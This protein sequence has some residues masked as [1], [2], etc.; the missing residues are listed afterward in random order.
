LKLRSRGFEF[1]PE[2]TSQVLKRGYKI[3]EVPIKYNPR[4]ILEGKKIRAKDGFIALWWLL[5]MKFLTK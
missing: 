5:K 4:G 3:V 2:F 1:C